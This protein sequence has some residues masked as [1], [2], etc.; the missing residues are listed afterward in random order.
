[1]LW[2]ETAQ[3][4][5][6]WIFQ[7]IL[8]R[9]GTLV[10]I[11]LDHGKLFIKH[12]Q[13]GSYN[14]H[15]N[16]IVERSHFDVQQALYKAA[17]GEQNRWAQVT[18]SVFWSEWVTPRKRMGYSPYYAA[19]GTYPLLPFDII[20]ANYLLPPPD[21]L[22]LSTDLITCCAIAL[23]KHTEDLTVLH[24][25]VLTVCNCVAVCFECK[26]STT[27]HNFEF[28]PGAL[29]LIQNTAIEKLLNHKMHLHYNG[30]VII[31]SRN[32]GSVYI[33][34]ELDSTLAQSPVAAFC[35]LPYFA[36]DHIDIPDIE[37]HI[38]ITVA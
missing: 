10:R 28:K 6:N 9:W 23:Q 36:H 11:I 25:H 3:A 16:G 5:G 20:E 13:I 14:P 32:H 17:N 21:S 34:C 15:A 26:H 24:D 35:I 19:T 27:I 22:L 8:C 33:I 38:T 1:M 2:K 4:I 12:I 18:H 29:V 37:D 31:D 7:D 30:P